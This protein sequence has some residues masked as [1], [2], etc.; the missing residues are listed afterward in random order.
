VETTRRFGH[1][2]LLAMGLG[3]GAAMACMPGAASADPLDLN[4]FD[5]NDFA[6]SIDGFTIIQLGTAT[7]HSGIGDFAIADGNDSNATAIG[8][9]GDVA[10]ASGTDSQAF[11]DRGN[12]DLAYASGWASS[13]T[14]AFGNND[15]ALAYNTASEA[16]AGG[17]ESSLGNNDFA[18]A[19]SSVGNVVSAEANDGSFNVASVYDPGGENGDNVGAGVG[20]G[21]YA[22]VIG[23]G[24]RAFAGGTTFT[25]LGN[26]NIAEIFGNSDMATAGSTVADPG[27]ADLA[28]V[29]GNG[30]DAIATGGNFLVDTAP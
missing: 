23:D 9:F 30:L 7:A 14:A 28:S 1:L 20:N 21:N 13:A 8:G 15:T 16:V 12:F 18:S 2:G 17:S 29:F 10:S 26:N 19:T 24:D 4:A 22:Y 25:L 3:V 6:I 11:V 27:S 5:P